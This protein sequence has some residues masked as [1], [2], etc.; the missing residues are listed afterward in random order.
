MI[1]LRNITRIY[2]R[3]QVAEDVVALND[4]SLDLPDKGF[5]SILGPS[6]CGKTTLLNVIGG[7]D[8][9]TS[10][11]MIVDN[12]S[13]QTFKSVDWN[14]YRNEKIGFVLQNCF[15]I[16]HLTVEENVALKLQISDRKFKDINGM[17]EEALRDVDLYDKR[18]DKPNQLSGGQKQRV[19]IARAIVGKPTVLLADEPTGA[20]DSKTGEQIMEILKKL[21]K[22]HLVVMV[23]HN[24]EYA[25]QY[26]DRI[27]EL[28]DGQILSDSNPFNVDVVIEDKKLS[29]VSFP[30][31][32]S[33]KWGFKNLFAKKSST[34]STILACS[35]GLTGVGL[36]ISMSSSVRVAFAEAEK[37]SLSQYPVTINSYS[38]QSSEGLEIEYEEYTTEQV[39]Y[40][41]LGNYSKQEH[42]NTMS[43]RFVKYMNDMPES[44]YKYKYNASVTNFK[45]YTQKTDTSYT[46]ISVGSIFY[47]SVN[48][49]NYNTDEYDCLSGKYPVGKNEVALIV[50]IYNRIDGGVL[51][52]L[53]FDSSLISVDPE[54]LTKK[55]PLTYDQIIGKTYQYVQ[56]DTYY[57]FNTT[58]DKFEKAPLTNKEFYEAGILELK[59]VG[60]LRQKETN[61]SAYYRTGVIYNQDLED[62]I[63]A[64]AAQS[65]IVVKQY[66]NGLD[67][68]VLTGQP[69]TTTT[70][71][72]VQYSAEYNYENTL[73]S[74]GAVPRITTLA[75]FTE[76]FI[77]REKINYYFN[78][79]VPDETVDVTRITYSDYI[80]KVSHEFSSLMELI[81]TVLYIFAIISVLISALLN[82][83]LTYIS[84][85]QRT[86]EI[87]LLRSLGARKKDIGMM[88]ETESLIMGL[89][90]G[91]LSVAI[92]AILVIPLN[93][94][95][96]YL[97]YRWNFYLLSKTTF[98]LS[99]F[100]WWVAPI[101]IGLALLTAFISALIPAVIAS[102]KD[103]ARAMN[104]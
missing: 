65:E 55:Y 47:K 71:G 16:P 10:G 26:S 62:F 40:V 29:K 54:D 15:L 24:R 83:I 60:I 51:Y 102:R 22:E 49:P 89:L 2:S 64:N 39:V 75:Y 95:L 35:L 78:Q 6:G 9:P 42:Y 11:N 81:T 76:D 12:I 38:K 31:L 33:L 85:H 7:L 17:V 92:A 14:S 84:V 94:G 28:K 98:T 36:I 52:N 61:L 18:K 103:P 20:L 56:N 74:I 68:S 66:E 104:E 13:T 21:S 27:I 5:I 86:N 77:S 97:I 93:E 57:K 23:T 79:Y 96:I 72:N 19:A 82:A 63:L 88:I 70:S 69:F 99:G 43:D 44:Y 1:S 41:D 32:T 3:K 25:E 53:G 67:K 101:L 59:I 100:Q 91:V 45:L 73:Y 34:I 48:S 87:G 8:A 4:V 58:K 37:N 50:D 46:D 80:D 90:G 30:L